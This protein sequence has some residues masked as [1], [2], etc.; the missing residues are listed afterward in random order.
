MYG[1]HGNP[2]ICVRSVD[3]RLEARWLKGCAYSMPVLTGFTD[4]R[5]EARWLRGLFFPMPGLIV[6]TD[7]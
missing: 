3:L 4:V 7:V 1:R 2:F 5:L 6:V